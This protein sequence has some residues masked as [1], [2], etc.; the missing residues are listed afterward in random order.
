MEGGEKGGD[1]CGASV[2]LVA[3]R[4]HDDRTAKLIEVIFFPCL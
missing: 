3:V 1:A 4:T 2:V